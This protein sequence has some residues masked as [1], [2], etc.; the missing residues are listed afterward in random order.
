MGL[1]LRLSIV[2]TRKR[3]F[4]YLDDH[5][6]PPA[7]AERSLKDVAL[8][9][10]LFGGTRAVLSEMQSL[11]EELS[12]E[13]V[14][15]FSLLD[16]GTGLGDIPAAISRRARRDA[17]AVR[18]TGIEINAPMAALPRDPPLRM[19]AADARALPFADNSFDVIICSQVLHHLDNG[20]AEQL[21]TE[22]S[23]VATRRVII[24]DLRRSWLAMGLLWL[25]SFPLRFHRLSR[26]DGVA[27]IRRGFTVD[28]LQRA[29]ITS[30][31]DRVKTSRRIG[32]RVTASWN[33]GKKAS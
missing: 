19:I 4:E 5:S 25:V 6:L 8:A 9:N 13:R 29:V 2:P 27:S 21:L 22:C 1:S 24:S 28:E 11:F 31:S 18:S 10:K 7:L 15:E 14:D 23:R 16:I 20:D 12:S 26:H 17:I 32:W 3:G 33:P 30:G